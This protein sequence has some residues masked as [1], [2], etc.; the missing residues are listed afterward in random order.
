V[1]VVPATWRGFDHGAMAREIGKTV[2][3]SVIELDLESPLGPG[4]LRL[5]VGDR[6]A[7]CLPSPSAPRW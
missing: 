4:D 2:G 3:F 6:R 1:L 7:H 5:P